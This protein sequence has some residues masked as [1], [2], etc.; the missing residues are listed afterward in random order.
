MHVYIYIIYCLL[1][2]LVLRFWLPEIFF[3]FFKVYYLLLAFK[4]IYMY[5]LIIAFETTKNSIIKIYT[6]RRIF[7]E[8]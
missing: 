8:K 4:N 7:E 1:F 6:T 2:V 5:I 3:N